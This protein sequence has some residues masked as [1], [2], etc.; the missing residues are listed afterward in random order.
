MEQS[1]K[2]M[3]VHMYRVYSMPVVFASQPR[4][5]VGLARRSPNGMQVILHLHTHVGPQLRTDHRHTPRPRKSGELIEERDEHSTREVLYR[6]CCLDDPC[7]TRKISSSMHV[8]RLQQTR[9]DWLS[10]TY[11]AGCVVHGCSCGEKSKKGFLSSR[12]IRCHVLRITARVKQRQ[13]SWASHWGH[14]HEQ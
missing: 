3:A 8:T 2:K 13:L 11:R 14:M 7:M 5:S 6:R 9:L 1:L 12:K 4:R 10:S